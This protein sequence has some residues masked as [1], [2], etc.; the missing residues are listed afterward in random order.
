MCICLF[1]V[2]QAE[3]EAADKKWEELNHTFSS[4]ISWIHAGTAH[5]LSKELEKERSR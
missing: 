1:Q 4:L 3:A 2:L 5:L